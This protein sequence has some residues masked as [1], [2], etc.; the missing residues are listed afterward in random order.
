[1]AKMYGKR[2]IEHWHSPD[3]I[4]PKSKLKNEEESQWSKE[5]QEELFEDT[6]KH[7]YGL[8]YDPKSGTYGCEDCYSDYEHY[9]NAELDD[10][11]GVWCNSDWRKTM[12]D[13]D[14]WFMEE[15]DERVS[16]VRKRREIE[17]AWKE[18]EANND[19]GL[20]PVGTSG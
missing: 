1:M 20:G 7:K 8:C 12:T 11:P 4:I 10:I 9:D 2:G 15:W 3:F 14:Y 16:S 17:Q 19:S 6:E 13:S 5:A 18:H